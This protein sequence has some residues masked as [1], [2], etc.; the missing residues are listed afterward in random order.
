MDTQQEIKQAEKD[1]VAI[2]LKND[3]DAFGHLLTDDFVYTSPACEVV[4]RAEYLE[5][6]RAKTVVMDYVNDSD[7]LIRVHGDVAVVTA[8]WQVKESY[9]GQSFEGACRITRVW[10]RQGGQW[11]AHTFQVTIC[12]PKQ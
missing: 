11:R 9:R 10:L 5:N 7:V 1:W 2:Y 8:G 4:H 12:G 6:L 3:A